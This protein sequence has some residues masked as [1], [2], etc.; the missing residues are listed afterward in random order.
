GFRIE[1]ADIELA[2]MAHEAVQ[3]AVVAAPE[4]PGGGKV[5]AAYI[6]LRGQGHDTAALPAQWRDWLRSRLPEYMIPVRF[7]V[8]ATLP[9]TP[10]GKIDR[11]NL[12]SLASLS[13]AG[14]SKAADGKEASGVAQAIR[15]V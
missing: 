14:Q 3:T 13:T 10:S 11:R 2:L 4:L 9:T 6:V 1:P 7:L 5:L 12:P 15:Q 8:V